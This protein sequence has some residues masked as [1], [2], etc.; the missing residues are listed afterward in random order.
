MKTDMKMGLKNIGK[1]VI[2]HKKGKAMT[3]QDIGCLEYSMSF[4]CALS[5]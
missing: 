1:C 3:L 2:D 5:R 4:P